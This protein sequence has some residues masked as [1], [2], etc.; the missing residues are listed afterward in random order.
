MNSKRD[1]SR[2]SMVY[3]HVKERIFS[4]RLSYFD[5]TVQSEVLEKSHLG[6]SKVGL[7]IV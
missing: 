7:I 2:V 4:F 3:D 5:I 1:F 6:K